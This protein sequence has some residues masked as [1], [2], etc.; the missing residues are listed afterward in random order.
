MKII[1]HSLQYPQHILCNAGTLTALLPVFRMAISAQ[2]KAPARADTWHKG[3]SI[4]LFPSELGSHVGRSG[5]WLHV[6]AARA[7]FWR[8][9]LPYPVLSPFWEP[10]CGVFPFFTTR[11][12]FPLSPAGPF[13]YADSYGAKQ[14]VDK[15]RKYEA[16]YGSQFTPCQLLLDY[17][18]SPGK[19]FHQ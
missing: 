6:S 12:R 19:K 2:T 5:Y 7:L 1:C 13:R 14:L 18:N 8:T 3:G 16:V 4:F 11:P 9:D 10:W 17:A 15:L